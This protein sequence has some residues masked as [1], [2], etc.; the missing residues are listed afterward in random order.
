M[1]VLP[2]ATLEETEQAAVRLQAALAQHD[3]SSIVPGLRCTA[4]FGIGS[5]EGD[6]PFEASYAHVDRLLALAKRQGRNRIGKDATQPAEAVVTQAMPPL[7]AF[8]GE[9]SFST[10]NQ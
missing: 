5:F 2:G 7:A 9:D 4:S 1:L 8:T 3:F 6:V 10:M